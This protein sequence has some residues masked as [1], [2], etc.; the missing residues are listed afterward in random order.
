MNDL[1]DMVSLTGT[2]FLGLT[3]GCARC[4]DHKFDPIAQKDFYGMQA[5]FAGVEHAERPVQGADAADRRREAETLRRELAR[6]DLR[7]DE[8]GAVGA[9]G[10]QAP[11]RPPVNPRRNVE[12][13]PPIEARFIRFTVA[14]T[15][16]G[17]EPCLDELEV[18]GPE[19][20]A[21]DLA[22]ASRA[23]RA[24]ASSVY[25]NNPF[26]KIEHLIDGRHG[27]GRSWIS[28]ERGKGWAQWSCRR[29][30]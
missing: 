28:N 4:H 23:A 19:A 12:R 11:A 29:L 14:A 22:L 3:V 20:P 8:P 25:P 21:D 30:R 18:Y 15:A 13:F 26:H 7:I 9:R 17:S 16:D 1:A 10:R 5:V 6:L 2:T 24:S 27:N